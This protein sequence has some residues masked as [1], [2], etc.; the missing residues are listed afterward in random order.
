MSV[1]T[2]DIITV[3]ITIAVVSLL[4]YFFG[5]PMMFAHTASE[6]FNYALLYGLATVLVLTLKAWY[7]AGKALVVV[8]PGSTATVN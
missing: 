3:I 4:A 1:Q 5:F 8:P 7:Q 6:V 2:Q